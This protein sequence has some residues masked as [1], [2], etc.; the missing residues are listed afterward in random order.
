MATVSVRDL[1]KLYEDIIA[2][3]SS[4]ALD[5]PPRI[6]KEQ[7]ATMRSLS[8]VSEHCLDVD[9]SAPGEPH[10]G[11][12][13]A[14]DPPMSDTVGQSA[15]KTFKPEP[16][17]VGNPRWLQKTNS[18]CLKLVFRR[19]TNLFRLH[20]QPRNRSLKAGKKC[21]SASGFSTTSRIH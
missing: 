2:A 17:S 4:D 21:S 6:L 18:G 20:K 14:I 10:R 3:A 15:N 19:L 11:V 1:V 8:D 9:E 13:R 12:L 7:A 5:N 16:P